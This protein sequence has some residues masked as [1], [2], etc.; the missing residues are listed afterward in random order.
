MELMRRSVYCN[1]VHDIKRVFILFHINA[2]SLKRLHVVNK[3]AGLSERWEE[4][5]KLCLIVIEQVRCKILFDVN[6]R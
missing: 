3:I 4:K 2:I 6:R 1:T 5:V